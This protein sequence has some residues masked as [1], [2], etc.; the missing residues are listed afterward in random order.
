MRGWGP[1]RSG[2]A[3][4]AALLP[5]LLGAAGKTA[6]IATLDSAAERELV[7][8]I[9]R[10]REQN[11]LP[12]LE[13]SPRLRDA[14]RAHALEMAKRRQLTHRFADEPE[15]RQRVAVTGVR[16]DFVGENVGRSEDAGSL[17]E[18]FLSS[19]GHRA[20]ILHAQANAV[21]VGAVRFGEEL[22]VTED[23]AHLV[24][25]YEPQQV[26]ELVASGIADLRKAAKLPEL[27]RGSPGPPREDACSMAQRDSVQFT[28]GDYPSVAGTLQTIA[29]A[30]ADPA[31]LPQALRDIVVRQ[32]PDR[33]SVG[34]C[35]ARTLSY[36]SG[37]YWIV[38]VFYFSP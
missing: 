15:L 12:K 9:N 5:L 31:P 10:S 28:H 4:L 27:R 35:A 2:R 19:P 22:F 17:H 11:G 33:F 30:T 16:F 36:P 23:F 38:V 21:G 34:A 18:E 20:N 14:P 37:G 3:A 26:E 7:E 29:Y 25:D 32:R 24:P 6:P 8:R 13:L 1:S